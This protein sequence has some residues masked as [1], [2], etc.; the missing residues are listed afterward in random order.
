M[1]R[2]AAALVAALTL[3]LAGCGGSERAEI[4]SQAVAVKRL[5]AACLAGQRAARAELGGS[6]SR[7]AFFAALRANMETILHRMD[8]VE[9]TGRAR[10][11]WDAYKDTLTTRL[12]ALARIT[13]ADRSDW[14][15]LIAADRSRFETVSA[16]AYRAIMGLGARHVCV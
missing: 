2:T 14:E 13:A 3:A 7:A 10:R 9:P 1:R 11:N 4:V 6:T 15:R 8:R 5:E 16:D 12:D